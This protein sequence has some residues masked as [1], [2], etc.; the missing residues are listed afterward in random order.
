MLTERLREAGAVVDEVTA[1]RTVQPEGLAAELRERLAG[2]PMSSPSPAPPRC[3]TSWR[4]WGR[5]RCRAL[6]GVAV[7]CIG[8]ITADTAR[9]TA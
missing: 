1:Y 2:R 4:P 8:P 5:T 9:R 6:D 3:S 7:A